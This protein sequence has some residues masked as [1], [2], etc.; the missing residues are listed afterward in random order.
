MRSQSPRPQNDAQERPF[1]AV[2]PDRDEIFDTEHLEHPGEVAPLVRAVGAGHKLVALLL[3]EA[4]ADPNEALDTAAETG[5]A[6][7]VRLLLAHGAKLAVNPDAPKIPSAISK[8]AHGG[9][10][11]AL[12]L[13]LDAGADKTPGAAAE[14]L[15]I[16][17]GR[18]EADVIRRLAS[19]GVDLNGR[20][21]QAR[22]PLL[23]ALNDPWTPLEEMWENVH[24]AALYRARPPCCWNW[25]P[26]Q[27]C[28]T[29]TA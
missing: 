18:G 26:I 25:G 22:T 28:T 19:R 3:L 14:A 11:A 24:A 4:G 27:T 29:T 10:V 17:I 13:L 21:E 2:G 16:A 23:A 12:D 6:D 8:A 20:D 15:R 1:H 5:R 9:H 7:L